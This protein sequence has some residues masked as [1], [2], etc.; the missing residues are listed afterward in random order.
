MGLVPGIGRVGVDG[1]Y[2]V[3]QMNKGQAAFLTARLL[4][5]RA[6]GDEVGS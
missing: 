6:F 4:P 5:L 3:A 1:H 2:L